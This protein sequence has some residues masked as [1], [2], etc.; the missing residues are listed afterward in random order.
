MS[1]LVFISHSSRDRKVAE[2]LCQA[3]EQHGIGC[4]ISSR[5]IGPGANFQ[6]AI[7]H[8]VRAARVMLLV[9]TANANNSNEIKKE[10]ALASQNK[11]AVV[12]VRV[13]DV[14]PSD[15]FAY[16]FA[17][18]QWID[19]IGDWQANVGKLVSYV[20]ELVN[21]GHPGTVPAAAP[22]ATKGRSRPALLVGLGALGVLAIVGAG[23]AWVGTRAPAPP[24]P[25]AAP[26]PPAPAS[27]AAPAPPVSAA[28]P[29]PASV[30]AKPAPISLTGKWLTAR[31]KNVYDEST[32]FTVQFDFDQSG[33]FL[34]GTVKE[35]SEAGRGEAK[36]IRGG[37][38][39]G[40]SISFYTQGMTTGEGNGLKPYKE[41]YH[42]TVQGDQIDFIRQNDISSGGLPEKFVAK[43]Q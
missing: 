4:W 21:D 39:S 42:G 35:L 30:A 25:V 32:I 34:T 12:P 17:T 20:A 31:L 37:Q 33:D 23:A 38:F 29:A 14:A 40:N 27:A 11:L 28:A 16:E 8:A 10:L 2:T 43:R 26:A 1:A 15:A 36:G 5:D 22:A 6:E 18:R 41:I 13:E 3:L 24:A 19:L 9:F 7:V